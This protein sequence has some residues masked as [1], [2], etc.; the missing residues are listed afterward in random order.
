[1]EEELIAENSASLPFWPRRQRKLLG[2]SPLRPSP[3]EFVDLR[4]IEDTELLDNKGDPA[5]FTSGMI[6]AETSPYNGSSLVSPINVADTSV[7]VRDQGTSLEKEFARTYARAMAVADDSY[8]NGSFQLSPSQRISSFGR[9]ID[10]GATLV[11]RYL[12]VKIEGRNGAS[13]KVIQSSTGYALPSTVTAIMGPPYSG[14]SSLLRSL[15]GVLPPNAKVYGEV[16]L[17]GRPRKLNDGTYA[18]VRK[19]GEFTETLTVRETLF[20]SAAMRLPVT[21]SCTEKISLVNDILADMELENFATMLVGVCFCGS[22]LAAGERR[23]LSIAIELL[24]RPRLIFVEEPMLQLDNV[25]GFLVMGSL[26]KLASNGCTVILTTQQTSTDIFNLFDKICLLARGRTLFFGEISACLE[27]FASSGLPCPRFQ[28]PSDHFLQAIDRD[29]DR[30]ISFKLMR[31]DLEQGAFLW[32]NLQTSVMVRTLETT[33]QASSEAAT[34]E[35]LVIQLSER[36]GPILEAPGRATF[37]AQLAA[38][39]WRSFLNMSRD[40]RFYWLRLILY[41]LLMCCIGTVYYKLEESPSS[42]HVRASAT[43]LSVSS[44]SLMAIGGFP[45]LVREV[46]VYYWERNIGHTKPELFV[47]GNMLS[48]MPFLLLISSVC[49]TIGYFLMGFHPTLSMFTYYVLTIFVCLTLVEGLLMLIS[50]IITTVFEGIVVAI[51]IEVMFIL[52]GGYFRQVADLPQPIWRYPA[53]YI[54]YQTYAVQDMAKMMNG[55]V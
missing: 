29:F 20:Y 55:K 24:T 43:F 6:T 30:V 15:A 27:H 28:N 41:I 18:Y 17:N 46:E 48:S 8:G 3:P 33:Y 44:L 36:K 10:H 14:K 45:S 13:Q 49:S 40:F 12:T 26:K 37:L 35:D 1:M 7:H 5:A 52:V 54:A 2:P 32:N 11:W 34:V 31:Q 25:S 9:K 23:R 21:V 42:I 16:H 39:T 38:V 50:S 53:S 22:G 4:R 19:G 51:S 47:L